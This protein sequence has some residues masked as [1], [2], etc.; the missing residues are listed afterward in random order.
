MK[1]KN[2]KVLG[3]N[4]FLNSLNGAI[5][6][7]ILGNPRLDYSYLYLDYTLHDSLEVLNPI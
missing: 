7:K 2:K 3:T 4:F 6:K 5:L 1:S